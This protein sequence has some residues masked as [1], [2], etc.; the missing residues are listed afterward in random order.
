MFVTPP[1]FTANVPKFLF[2]RAML[3][4]V[5][6]FI[7]WSIAEY[8]SAIQYYKSIGNNRSMRFIEK[9]IT[10]ELVAAKSPDFENI[11]KHMTQEVWDSLEPYQR[12]YLNR[13]YKEYSSSVSA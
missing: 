13:A 11:V 9:N 6:K 8:A 3:L 2:K 7:D 5:T 12:R 4:F 10:S 1:T